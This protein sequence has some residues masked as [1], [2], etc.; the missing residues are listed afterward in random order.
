MMTNFCIHNIND[1]DVLQLVY[2]KYGD[3]WGYIGLHKGDLVPRLLI[4]TPAIDKILMVGIVFSQENLSGLEELCQ[5]LTV[6]IN[7]K[8]MMDR[9]GSGWNGNLIYNNEQSLLTMVERYLK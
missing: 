2:N 3:L 7:D 1:L 5:S 8:V 6:I 4:E 9:I